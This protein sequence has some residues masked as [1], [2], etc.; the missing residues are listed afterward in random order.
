MNDEQQGKPAERRERGTVKRKFVSDRNGKEVVSFIGLLDIAHQ[1]GMSYSHVDLIQ[2]PHP[3]NKQTAICI[4]TVKTAFGSFTDIGDA[5]PDNVSKMIQPHFVRMASTRALARALRQATNVGMLCDDEFEEEKPI[6]QNKPPQQQQQR[7]PTTQPAPRPA[8]Q[9]S[10]PQPPLDTREQPPTDD[11]PTPAMLAGA[12]KLVVEL[13]KLTEGKEEVTQADAEGLM[14]MRF[15]E[16]YG[17]PVAQA[18]RTDIASF[19][20]TLTQERRNQTRQN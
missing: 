18:T 7:P 10:Q 4:A 2:I 5:N 17:K 8:P 13:T 6:R 15:H 3:D 11:K 19:H 16:I 14:R 9:Q 20:N 1:E 12:L